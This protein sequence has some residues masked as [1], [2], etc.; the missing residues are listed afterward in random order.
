MDATK[1]V[2]EGSDEPPPSPKRPKLTDTDESE[3][4][5]SK[6]VDVKVDFV[7]VANVYT[8]KVLLPKSVTIRSRTST[9][10][11]EF[12]VFYINPTESIPDDVD[13]SLL[14]D[15]LHNLGYDEYFSSLKVVESHVEGECL[16]TDRLEPIIASSEVLQRLLTLLRDCDAG[17]LN[18]KPVLNLVDDQTR[19][20]FLTQ[21]R[22]SPVR[23]DLFDC[24]ERIVCGVNDDDV[25]EDD[26]REFLSDDNIDSVKVGDDDPKTTQVF[27]DAVVLTYENEGLNK[28]RSF[29]HSFESLELMR[30]FI[31][32]HEYHGELVKS[33]FI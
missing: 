26:A 16:K 18:G 7:A 30:S 20:F 33:K 6:T 31:F 14:F 32:V 13:K 25:D 1:R 23:K 2:D 29:L 5:S 21:I 24:V 8:G 19:N 9:D 4:T 12:R 28:Y 11:P 27:V 3:P 15:E 22:A 10:D 17:A